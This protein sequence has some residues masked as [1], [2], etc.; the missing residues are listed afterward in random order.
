MSFG[1]GGS[2]NSRGGGRI[3]GGRGGGG[4]GRGVFAGRPRAVLV[5]TMDE[6][7]A[8]TTPAAEALA[9][10]FTLCSMRELRR[11]VWR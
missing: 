7:V 9:T 3:R 1:L 6:M 8:A 10:L 2:G 4:G 11:M 5:G